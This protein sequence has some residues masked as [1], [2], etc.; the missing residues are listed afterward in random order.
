MMSVVP[1]ASRDAAQLF[2][3]INLGIFIVHKYPN[4]FVR[5][6]KQI[7]SMFQTPS[8]LRNGTIAEKYPSAATTG[9]KDPK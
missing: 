1:S 3:S 9:D 4:K 2:S 8:S 6:A 7:I 5:F